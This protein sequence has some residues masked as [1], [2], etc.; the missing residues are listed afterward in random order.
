MSLFTPDIGLLFW[1]A[2]SFGIVLFILAR[3]G[4]PVITRMVD[5]RKRYID[6]S[7][8]AAR[9]ANEKLEHIKTESEAILAKAREEQMAIL[10]EA[11]ETRDRIV[12]EAREKA[13]TEGARL[14]EETRQQIAHGREKALR[15]LRQETAELA[16][17]V[18]EKVIRRQL[19][20]EHQQTEL[21]ERL[22][23]EVQETNA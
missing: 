18:A 19:D 3:F 13:R 10:K 9:E 15:D 11:M 5:E 14:M 4:F 12:A 21:I 23:D 7:I 1:M 22:L 6:E 20:G 2:L 8:D 16:V 17:A